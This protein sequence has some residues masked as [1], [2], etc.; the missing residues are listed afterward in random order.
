MKWPSER[1]N[2]LFRVR[3]H[4]N[5]R[6]GDDRTQR[7]KESSKKIARDGLTFSAVIV[8]KYYEDDLSDE[9]YQMYHNYPSL[10]FVDSCDRVAA[11]IQ[12]DGLKKTKHKRQAIPVLRMKRKAA[13]TPSKGSFY[14]LQYFIRLTRSFIQC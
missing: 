2:D 11:S 6:G 9:H 13:Y 3:Q 7:M 4:H 1:D 10:A 14:A 8:A 12:R 5:R